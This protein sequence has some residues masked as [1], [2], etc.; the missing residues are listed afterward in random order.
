MKSALQTALLS[1]AMHRAKTNKK[2][3]L[4]KMGYTYT[5]G[6]MGFNKAGLI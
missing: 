3:F 5:M 2:V 1:D 6:R 4:E